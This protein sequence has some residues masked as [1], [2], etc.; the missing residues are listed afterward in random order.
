MFLTTLTRLFEFSHSFFLLIDSLLEAPADLNSNNATYNFAERS[1][2]SVGADGLVV[3]LCKA[4]KHFPRHCQQ[5]RNVANNFPS[6]LLYS[7]STST[8]I[9][10]SNVDGHAAYNNCQAEGKEV[11][12]LAPVHNTCFGERERVDRK[13]NKLVLERLASKHP[14]AVTDA[15]SHVYSLDLP[16]MLSSS[17]NSFSY[18]AQEELTSGSAASG[19]TRHLNTER[20][21]GQSPLSNFVSIPSQ[22]MTSDLEVYAESNNTNRNTNSCSRGTEE[23]KR[24]GFR[25][26]DSDSS[27]TR[28]SFQRSRRSRV[29]SNRTSGDASVLGALLQRLFCLYQPEGEIATKEPV[30]NQ[31]KTDTITSALKCVWPLTLLELLKDLISL[32]SLQSKTATELAAEENGNF[33]DNA[34]SMT[35]N[36]E[37]QM[38]FSTLDVEAMTDKLFQISGIPNRE[39]LRLVASWLRRNLTAS[40][41]SSKKEELPDLSNAAIML[42]ASSDALQ[43][44]VNLNSSHSVSE[45]LQHLLHSPQS[46]EMDFYAKRKIATNVVENW[47]VCSSSYKSFDGDQSCLDAMNTE[48]PDGPERLLPALGLVIE[49]LTEKVQLL[50]Q[51]FTAQVDLQAKTLTAL[52]KTQSAMAQEHSSYVTFPYRDE[53]HFPLTSSCRDCSCVTFDRRKRFRTSFETG[54]FCSSSGATAAASE[55]AKENQS[56]KTQCESRPS[57]NSGNGGD[58]AGSMDKM[59]TSFCASCKHGKSDDG[60]GLSSTIHNTH[61]QCSQAGNTTTAAMEYACVTDTV[62]QQ[63]PLEMQEEALLLS[64]EPA[65]PS[66]KIGLDINENCNSLEPDKTAVYFHKGKNILHTEVFSSCSRDALQEIGDCSTLNPEGVFGLVHR[67]LML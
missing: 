32:Q 41:P 7:A 20:Q 2:S 6:T 51:A 49:N 28:C 48:R 37:S 22:F 65:I 27:R 8:G 19:R 4:Q 63:R 61:S 53:A 38:I 31:R 67:F 40:K 23:S 42:P 60:R 30:R 45:S 62:S 12:G 18:C 36:G 1:L 16:V 56:L 35:G 58:C 9:T 33:R 5:D 54:T 26:G 55:N 13:E 39:F 17:S 10:Q 43:E 64:N 50:Q 34:A 47:P 44:E 66:G 3:S 59:F 24:D 52:A 29:T 57:C 15:P 11:L 21:P 46:N 14:E 25:G